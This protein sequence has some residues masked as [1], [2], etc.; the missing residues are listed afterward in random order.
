M[1]STTVLE[2]GN[3]CNDVIWGNADFGLAPYDPLAWARRDAAAPEKAAA[4]FLDLL[5]QRDGGDRARDA[6]LRAGRDGK[7]DG[8]RKALQLAVHC[9]EYQL[10]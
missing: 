3:W 6:V 8:L 4:A 1:N 5:L 10:A 7:P 9:P 2:R